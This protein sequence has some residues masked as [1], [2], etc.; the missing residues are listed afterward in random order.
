MLNKLSQMA[1][2]CEMNACRRKVIL[3]YFGEE[4]PDNCGSCDVCTSI[5]EK[6]DGTI[7]AQKAL[8]AVAR[9]DGRFG[10]SYLVDFLRGSKSEKIKSYH[11]NLKTYG[12]GADIPKEDWFRYFKDL[13]AFGYL[14][15]A[16]DEYPI[17][18][19]TEKSPVV[20]RGE[21]NHLKKI[22]LLN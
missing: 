9:L 16:G 5:R 10:L 4:A 18:Q 7:I 21:E 22:Y 17:I 2:L 8:S 3:N 1:S 14:R 6:F 11:K 20:L 19:L 13:I 12:V 15:Q